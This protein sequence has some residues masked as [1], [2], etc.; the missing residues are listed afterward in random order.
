MKLEIEIPDSELHEKVVAEMVQ[1][2]EWKIKEDFKAKVARSIEMI[3][4]ATVSRMVT[5]YLVAEHIGKMRCE[6]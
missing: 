1:R 6:K 5:E 2:I 3:D 4:Q